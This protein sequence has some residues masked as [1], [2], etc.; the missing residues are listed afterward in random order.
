M[1]DNLCDNAL[2]LSSGKLIVGN[3]LPLNTHCQWLISAVDDQD[4]VNLEI[5][6]INVS[7]YE[8]NYFLLLILLSFIKLLKISANSCSFLFLPPLPFVFSLGTSDFNDIL[9]RGQRGM[10]G[11]EC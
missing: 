4:Y 8:L 10:L 11:H 5:P 6:Y 2:D 9:S 1:L 3:N 7:N